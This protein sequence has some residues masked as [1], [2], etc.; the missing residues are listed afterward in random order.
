MKHKETQIG[1]YEIKA[2]IGQGGTSVVY[3]AV[4]T[5]NQSIVALKV[6]T[7]LFATDPKFLRRFIN[8][9]QNVKRLDHPNIV[10]IYE[11]NE[12]DGRQYIAME[13]VEGGSLSE[14]IKNRNSLL[15]IDEAL[16][17]IEQ[18]AAA[19]DY[20]HGLGIL[21]RDIKL[22]NILLTQDGRAL[23]TDF[24]SAKHM[25]GEHTVVTQSGF[26]VGTPTFMSPEQ[27]KGDPNIDR[28]T[29]VYSLG[30]AAYA[31]LVGRLPFKADSQ[32]AL[33]H[34][35]IY[36]A[37]PLPELVNPDIAPGIAYALKRVLS[38]EPPMRYSTAG[39]FA[40]AL[41]E[42]K[43]WVP[44]TQDYTNIPVFPHGTGSF[45][46]PQQP[47]PPQRRW[48]GL[49]S[50]FL[51]FGIT[52]LG[53]ILALLISTNPD[54]ITRDTNLSTPT[55]ESPGQLSVP[56][57]VPIKPIVVTQ[58]SDKNNQ[59]SI[60]VPD[61]WLRSIREDS[62]NFDSPDFF[63]RLF[64][65]KIDDVPSVD[66]PRNVVDEYLASTS[67]TGETY[68]NQSIISD[69]MR[70]F[71]D[72]TVRELVLDATWLGTNVRV[73]LLGFYTEEEGYVLGSIMEPQF[74]TELSSILD[75]AASSFVVTPLADRI[76]QIP[77]VTASTEYSLTGNSVLSNTL[78]MTSSLSVNRTPT[79]P[80]Y[81]PTQGA[82]VSPTIEGATP[83]VSIPL[84][85]TPTPIASP[86]PTSTSTPR[87]MNA[88]TLEAERAKTAESPPVS[89]IVAESSVTAI[90]T[91]ST[92][93][94]SRTTGNLTTSL[95]VVRA[96]DIATRLEAAT[97]TKSAQATN[98]ATNVATQPLRA[99]Q[100]STPKPT[101]TSTP[102]PS[103][104]TQ[105]PTK[106]PTLRPTAT[107]TRQAT[108]Q[109][110]ATNTNTPRPTATK[111]NTPRATAT[112]TPTVPTSTPTK[113]PTSTSTKTPFPTATNS[114]TSTDTPE[115]TETPEPTDTPRP[116]NTLAPFPSPTLGSSAPI[117]G[118]AIQPNL[119]LSNDSGGGRIIFEWSSNFEP[120]NGQGYELVFWRPGQAPVANSFGLAA[121]TNNTSVAV[122]LS[123]LDNALG[124]LLEPGIYNWGVLLVQK[125]PY[126]RV[127]YLGGGW[128]Y[129]Y[130]RS[131]GGRSRSPS[132]GE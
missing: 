22:S 31:I 108:L 88:A 55:S 33:L 90:P 82:E 29:D 6:L 81:T 77:P 91:M 11:T 43:S 27:A 68:R 53:I 14:L 78:S 124:D 35:I 9:G 76:G 69:E 125:D 47:R 58:Y 54:F 120:R 51:L 30:I 101:N 5:R 18:T 71:G 85:T 119:P 122:D 25:Y 37:P 38:K 72:S 99:T 83:A 111:T 1:P 113:I 42:G 118:A 117:P 123:A 7:P 96:T 45:F 46:V 65:Q 130:I 15:P 107:D 114:P 102:R 132:S 97:A 23:L 106:A 75:I 63:A 44:G 103:T 49:F 115:P 36:D 79:V 92:T 16:N 62:I 74:N 94:T 61:N 66:S 129:E 32:V 128:Q 34:K 21:H 127:Q 20:A 19:L 17:I 67:E 98:T 105:T 12:A 57:V 8:E 13:L 28:R 39:E 59:F 3:R 56:S 40:A 121:S 86:T 89:R 73:R 80:I 116:T 60:N 2:K 52:T 100:T 10:Q 48:L 126:R 110:I 64:L 131:S 104:S 70:S 4:D 41:I 24:G 93:A 109:P 95:E 87:I 112:E 26:S 84:R 50:L